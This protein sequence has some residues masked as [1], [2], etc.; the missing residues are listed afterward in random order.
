ML[1]KSPIEYNEKKEAISSII[2]DDLELIKTKE[3]EE[4]S[5]LEN[6]LTP[7]SCF[8]KDYIY[9]WSKFYTTDEIFLKETQTLF[10]T[11]EFINFNIDI[12]K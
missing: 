11:R 12:K 1:Y 7:E 10:K 8:G 3:K 9:I 2:V 5:I 4:H 6:F